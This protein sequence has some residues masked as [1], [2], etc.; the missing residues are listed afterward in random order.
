MMHAKKKKEIKEKIEQI[1]LWRLIIISANVERTMIEKKK[2]GMKNMSSLKAAR[3]LRS[4]YRNVLLDK[5][6][7]WKDG[8]MDEMSFSDLQDYNEFEEIHK[9]KEVQE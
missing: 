2:A 4:V 5:L 8:E 6:N 3:N 7:K 1:P 9:S